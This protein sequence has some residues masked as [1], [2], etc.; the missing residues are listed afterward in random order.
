MKKNQ[1][2][3]FRWW[4]SLKRGLSRHDPW[5]FHGQGIVYHW[6]SDDHQSIFRFRVVHCGWISM[7]WDGCRYRVSHEFPW[8]VPM[9]FPF[10]EDLSHDIPMYRWRSQWSSHLQMIFPLSSSLICRLYISHIFQM[11]SY[12]F[13]DFF[14]WSSQKILE[15]IGNPMIF[16]FSRW[17]PIVSY[18]FPY[19]PNDL[20]NN[21]MDPAPPAGH[22]G[23][24]RH[25]GAL[26]RAVHRAVRGADGDR[27]RMGSLGKVGVDTRNMAGNAIKNCISSN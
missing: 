11:I 24:G 6:I 21:S 26:C 8:F 22:G 15:T 12:S 20:P 23:C 1:G 27:L 18:S 4:R 13:Q 3:L 19:F 10:A 5:T 25:G 2:T 9:I 7:K 16:L 14:R 17:F